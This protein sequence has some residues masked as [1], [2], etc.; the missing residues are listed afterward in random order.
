MTFEFKNPFE[1][2]EKIKKISFSKELTE[3]G[4]KIEFDI[5]R[6]KVR[7]VSITGIETMARAFKK[8][9]EI[10]LRGD[11][12]EIADLV[13][14]KEKQLMRIVAKERPKKGKEN[15]YIKK[16]YYDHQGRKVKE[17]GEIIEG[18]AKGHRWECWFNLF[19]GKIKIKGI[20]KKDIFISEMGRSI[21]QGEDS[22]KLPAGESWLKGI[23]FAF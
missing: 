17:E 2:K 15:T 4:K 6:I 19:L 12:Q 18:P 14:V 16:T 5:K 8:A 9:I 10:E 1:K 13:E 3:L 23:A 22:K 21:V 20:G 11:W 7:G